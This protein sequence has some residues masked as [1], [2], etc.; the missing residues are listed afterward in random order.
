MI[1]CGHVGVVLAAGLARLGHV[2]TG[3]D[4]IPGT[5]QSLAHGRAPFFED[6]LDAL[7]ADGVESGRLA[8]TTSYDEGLNGAEFVFL[9]VDTPP[10]DDGAPDL[11]NI[12]SAAAS[13]G[14]A[15]HGSHPLVVIKST[16]PVGTCALVEEIIASS[17]GL[18]PTRTR[19]LSNPEFLRQGR[20]VDDF[21]GPDRT[22]IGAENSVDARTVARLF[23]QLPG[24]LVITDVATAEMIKYASNAYLATR[25][26]FINEFAALC[27]AVGVD[28]D[29]VVE[30]MGHDPRIGHAFN[31]PGIG[32]GG[33]CLPKDL[34]A[35]RHIATVHGVRT[36]LLAAVE[37]VNV[38]QPLRAVR[39]LKAAL[40][41]DI[42]GAVVAVWGVTF[43]GETDDARRSPA[44][45]VITLLIDEG[46]RVRIYDPSA[47]AGLP[48]H[49]ER[50]V[51]DDPM[52]AAQDAD[53]VAIL[54]DW[55]EFADI[56]LDHLHGVMRGD[57]ILD[58]RNV[59]DADTALGAGFVYVGMGRGGTS[60]ASMML[61]ERLNRGA[62]RTVAT[63][64]V[65]E[66]DGAW[67]IAEAL[68]S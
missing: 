45:D 43:K 61:A 66:M 6:G 1:G 17:N 10:A 63:E 11:G 58:G 36:P 26:S 13:L 25:L 29:G 68:S 47:A 38:S 55:R 14:G 3:V 23:E 34:A 49:L 18:S 8:F 44:I 46:A 31:R 28:I 12:R 50:L 30:G 64:N 24:Q 42:D 40:G 57:V 62:T 20:A 35:V 16:V 37:A 9:A 41:G 56:D 22:V 19:V 39:R 5:V 33:S 59:L 21:F 32:F 27:D 54:S 7:L 52:V 51:T 67:E 48:P 65:Q 15:L 2:V 53:A 60:P 4:R